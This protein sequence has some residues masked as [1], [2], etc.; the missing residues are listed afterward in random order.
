MSV[1]EIF[2]LLKGLTAAELSAAS[3]YFSDL[4]KQDQSAALRE[5]ADSLAADSTALERIESKVKQLTPAQL[6][7]LG[8][9]LENLLEDRLELTEEFKASIERGEQDIHDPPH[10][11]FHRRKNRA[12]K[13]GDTLSF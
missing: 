4:E 5:T 7:E 3:Q 9:W 8:E 2:H 1:E 10:L 11:S 6:D 13:P 12:L